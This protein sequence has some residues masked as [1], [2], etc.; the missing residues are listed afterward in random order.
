VGWT[1]DNGGSQ[2]LQLRDLNFGVPVDNILEDVL[3]GGLSL[4]DRQAGADAGDGPRL[5]GLSGEHTR[6][7]PGSTAPLL[8]RYTWPDDRSG[9]SLRLDFDDGCSISTSW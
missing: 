4:I 5:I 9:Y 6:I 7:H 1:I 2:E 3:L 8:L